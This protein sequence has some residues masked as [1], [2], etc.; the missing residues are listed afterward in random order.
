MRGP[1]DGVLA[2]VHLDYSSGGLITALGALG[3][4]EREVEWAS[5]SLV[6]HRSSAERRW[7]KAHRAS[8]LAALTRSTPSSRLPPRKTPRIPE[9]HTDESS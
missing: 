3:A 2:A 7:V 9:L 8:A 5:F 1:S 4:A 6:R